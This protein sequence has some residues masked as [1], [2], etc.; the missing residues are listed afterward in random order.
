MTSSVFTPQDK[1]LLAT[2]YVLAAE[3]REKLLKKKR[4][5]DMLPTM[6]EHKAMIDTPVESSLFG[7][8]PANCGLSPPPSPS[9]IPPPVDRIDSVYGDKTSSTPATPQKHTPSLHS[10]HKAF[11]FLN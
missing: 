1:A 5:K 8:V 6:E 2:G 3:E 4:Q 7:R 10:P 11:N 9:Q